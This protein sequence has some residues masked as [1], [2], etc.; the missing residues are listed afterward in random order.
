MNEQNKKEEKN[1]CFTQFV[2]VGMLIILVV[3]ILELYEVHRKLE[4]LEEN[5]INIVKTYEAKEVLEKELILN[6]LCETKKEYD[7]MHEML[8]REIDIAEQKSYEEYRDYMKKIYPLTYDEV[9]G[10][11]I[12]E[13]DELVNS[14]SK[15]NIYTFFEEIDQKW[16]ILFF[17]RVENTSYNGRNVIIKEDL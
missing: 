11:W 4:I 17:F 6:L 13:H 2:F 14:V 5:N 3:L 7:G 16:S 8:N 12:L 9:V 1:N 10:N 15:H